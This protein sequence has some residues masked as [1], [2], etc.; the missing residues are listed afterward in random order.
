M[1][2]LWLSL[3]ISEAIGTEGGI[4]L[5]D[6]EYKNSCRI[7]LE[8]CKEYYAITCGVYGS[9][10]HTAFSDDEHYKTKYEDMKKELQRFIDSDCSENEENEFYENFCSKY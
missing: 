2:N 9:M 1:A 5:A 3:N 7:T 8:K 4:V 10:M 6:E